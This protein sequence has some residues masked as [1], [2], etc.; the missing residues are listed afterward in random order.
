MTTTTLFQNLS[1]RRGTVAWLANV[2]F[3][4]HSQRAR[5]LRNL[6]LVADH[7][8]GGDFDGI[9]FNRGDETVSMGWGEFAAA[10]KKELLAD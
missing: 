1:S 3:C 2:I 5:E 7:V 8:I 4:H 6:A 10:S 9:Q